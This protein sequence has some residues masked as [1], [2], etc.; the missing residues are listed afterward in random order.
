MPEAGLSGLCPFVVA[1]A[2][3]LAALGGYA[4]HLWRRVWRLQRQRQEAASA[5]R[6][7]LREDLRIL[8]GAL[9]EE[10]LPLIEGAIRIKVLLD[11]YDPQ[12]SQDSRSAV[13]QTLYAATADIPTHADWQA[14]ERSERRRHEVRFGELELQHKAAAR[15]AA[16]WLLDEGLSPTQR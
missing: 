9:L 13:F 8:A 14:L 5:S 7:Q 1:A 16:R 3:L 10:Q 15:H 4:L 6:E 11:N 12:L 2:L